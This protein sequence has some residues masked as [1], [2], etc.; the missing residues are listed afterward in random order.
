MIET[1][2]DLEN[3]Y[4]SAQCLSNLKS[5]SAQNKP[6]AVYNPIF[7]AKYWSKFKQTQQN[8]DV[9]KIDFNVYCEEVPNWFESKTVLTTIHERDCKKYNVYCEIEEDSAGEQFALGR[10][11]CGEQ[12]VKELNREINSL[13]SIYEQKDKK[14]KILIL[15]PTQYFECGGG[16]GC[17]GGC[18][19]SEGLFRT[20]IGVGYE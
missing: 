19:S 13:R 11:Q 16:F 2:K 17:F 6:S 20:I 9:G 8:L 18:S 3:L 12:H 4:Y 1:L 14:I 10:E 5:L 7:G 15:K